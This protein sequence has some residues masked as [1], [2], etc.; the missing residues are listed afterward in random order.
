MMNYVVTW[1][2]LTN[3][4]SLQ[5]DTFYSIA[6]IDVNNIYLVQDLIYLM[7]RKQMFQMFKFIII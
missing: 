4:T 7:F 6:L 2:I 5:V 3:Y 1:T